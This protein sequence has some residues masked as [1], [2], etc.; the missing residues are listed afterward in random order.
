MKYL[1]SLLVLLC[2]QFV[3]AQHHISE[4]GT[5]VDG[6]ETVPAVIQE[7]GSNDLIQKTPESAEESNVLFDPIPIEDVDFKGAAKGQ[8]SVSLNGAAIYNLPIEVP[9]GI[10]GIEPK[11]GITYSSQA[12][13]GIA[14]YGWN[15][16]GSSTIS[17][18]GSNKYYDGK[19]SVVNYSSDDRFMLDGQRLLLKSGT[20]EANGAEYQTET[21]SNL[22][23]TSHG[24]TQSNNGPEYFK[25]QYPDGSTAYYGRTYSGIVPGIPGAKTSTNTAYALTYL[26]NPQNVVINYH[27]INDDRNLLISSIKYGY[28]SI[29]PLSS[30]LVMSGYNNICF[31]YKNRNRIECGYTYGDS[32]IITKILDK[33]TVI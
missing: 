24:T 5:P 22:K 28:R 3:A 25:V 14:G 13:N 11:I 18:I 31:T 1:Y 12:G 9:P 29:N 32:S 2:T 16:S 6:L 8:F 4:V 10:N 33:I 7:N 20:Y 26:I 15:I 23:I 27:Y 17:K 30:L 19:N 21:Y